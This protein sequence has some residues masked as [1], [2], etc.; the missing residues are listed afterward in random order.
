MTLRNRVEFLI[1]VL[2][3]RLVWVVPT[4]IAHAFGTRVARLVFAARGERVG[5]ALKNLRIAFPELSEG[6]RREIGRRSY[7]NFARNLIDVARSQVWSEAEFRSRIEIVGL[8]HLLAARAQGKGVLA[9]T[10]HLG[11]FELAPRALGVAGVPVS[12]V[13]RRL[14]NPLL[15]AYLAAG[16][17]TAGAELIDRKKGAPS[18]LRALR[19][20]RTVGL[21]IDQ[22]SS[23][24]RGVFVPLFGVRCSTSAGLATLALRTGAPVVPFYM[25]RDGPDHHRAVVLSALEFLPSGQRKHDIEALTTLCNEVLEDLIRHYPEQWMWAHRRFRHSPDLPEPVYACQMAGSPHSG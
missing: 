6:S 15:Y 21:L 5:Y 2:V 10:L 9:L 4:R 14:R 19:Q 18:I 3:R 8:E 22:Y 23:R 7:E 13:A 25:L 16:R 17:R 24:A 12:S 1:L 11:N 20:G